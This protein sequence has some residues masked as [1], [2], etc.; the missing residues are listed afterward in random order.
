MRAKLIA[1]LLMTA[2]SVFLLSGSAYDKL[3][4]KTRADIEALRMK[5]VSFSELPG[6]TPETEA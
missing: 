4:D 5:N 2:L 6:S 1:A 3:G